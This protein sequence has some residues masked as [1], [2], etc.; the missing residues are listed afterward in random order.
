[1][2]KAGEFVDKHEDKDS[3]MIVYYGGHAFINE[4]R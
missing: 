1:M 3:L 4:A 2:L